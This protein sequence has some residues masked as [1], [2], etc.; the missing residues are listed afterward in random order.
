MKTLYIFP[1]ELPGYFI[2][3]ISED[4]PIQS[5]KEADTNAVKGLKDENSHSVLLLERE[6]DKQ[7]EVIASCS[8]KY[9]PPTG[10]SV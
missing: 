8:E 6:K 9:Y 3:T 7:S 10:L 2:F 1:T 5:I 4:S